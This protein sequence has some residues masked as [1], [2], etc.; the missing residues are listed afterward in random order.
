MGSTGHGKARSSSSAAPWRLGPA[1][2]LLCEDFQRRPLQSRRKA[3]RRWYA[4]G[5]RGPLTLLRGNLQERGSR[6]GSRGA[7]GGRSTGVLLGKGWIGGVSVEG[8]ELTR[9]RFLSHFSS[10]NFHCAASGRNC[11]LRGSHR[12]LFA[13]GNKSEAVKGEK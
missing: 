2:P 10:L 11:S 5:H 6:K 9:L 7:E 13:A 3:Q 4:G 8:T 12:I 1:R